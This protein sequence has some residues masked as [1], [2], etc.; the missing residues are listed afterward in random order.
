MEY[1]DDDSI[2]ALLKGQMRASWWVACRERNCPI[3][4]TFLG[5]HMLEAKRNFVGQG[6]VQDPAGF[7]YCKRHAHLTHHIH[8]V[9]NWENEG[10][11]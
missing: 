5:A 3:E 2:S 7:W 11:Q 4:Y 10:G 1:F 6:W 9:S 8:E